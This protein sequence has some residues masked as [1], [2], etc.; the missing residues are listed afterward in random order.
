[1]GPQY[2][3][4]KTRKSYIN[5]QITDTENAIRHLNC[6]MQNTFRHLATTKLKQIMDSNRQNVIHKRHQ[7]N[8]NQI[9]NI[10][11]ENNLAIVKADKS[12]AIVIINQ[13]NIKT[14]N[15]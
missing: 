6:N 1:M 3:I 5:E 14:K 2:A 8:I 11:K 9:K 10:L 7:H 4:E 13:K 15:G 12:K